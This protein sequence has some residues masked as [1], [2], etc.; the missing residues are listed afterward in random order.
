[1]DIKNLGTFDAGSRFE[2]DVVIVGSGP[3]GLTVAREFFQTSTRILIVENGLIDE[4]PDYAAL[5]KLESI[6]E[7]VPRSR[8]GGAAFMVPVHLHGRRNCSRTGV[9]CR[10][11]GGSTHAWAGKSA[12]LDPI[13]FVQRP[14]VPHSGWPIDHRSLTPFLDRAIQVLNLGPNVGGE[15]PWNL[16]G[17]EPPRP[18]LDSDGLRSFLLAIRSI[19]LRPTR[20]DAFWVKN[21]LRAKPTTSECC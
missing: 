14:W 11:F 5:N 20:R 7:P 4:T 16:M 12:P 19:A 13:D 6:G 2:T 9:R 15:G 3:A 18:E 8:G 21:L 17:I 10:A 1:M